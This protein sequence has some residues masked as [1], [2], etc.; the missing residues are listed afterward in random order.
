MKISNLPSG[1]RELAELRAKQFPLGNNRGLVD[2]IFWDQTPE[3]GIF[4]SGVNSGD[5]RSYY[6]CR[7]INPRPKQLD[8]EY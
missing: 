7:L 2:D 8:P 6:G 3:H 1:L 5:F 4:W